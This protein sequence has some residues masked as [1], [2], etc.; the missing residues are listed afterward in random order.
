MTVS[1]KVTSL[2]THTRTY[3]NWHDSKTF[4][5]ATLRP[6]SLPHGFELLLN[7]LQSVGEALGG[8]TV[9]SHVCGREKRRL[10][11]DMHLHMVSK[12]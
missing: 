3:R 9:V 8:R 5:F 11:N 6:I 7:A 1:F 10:E 4:K 12:G 2:V